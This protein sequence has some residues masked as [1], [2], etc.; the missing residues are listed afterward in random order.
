MHP[1]T[2][3]RLDDFEKLFGPRGACGGCWCMWWRLS[4]A[5]YEQ[6][7][8][9]GNRAAMR[10]L[11]RSGA[12]P[13]VIALSDDQAVGWCG[14]GP[15]S[16]YIRLN[17]SRILRPVRGEP[18]P[19]PAAEGRVWSVVCFYVARDHR[20]QGVSARLLEGAAGLAR[21]RGATTLEGYPLD[22]A[23]SP[24]GRIPDLF[25]FPGIASTFVAAGFREVARRS[26]GR[27]I[28]QRTLR[29]SRTRR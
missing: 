19:A 5:D 7:K 8:G 25:A 16:S 23:K 10:R 29:A 26:P 3:D 2:P 15:R 28:M 9:A 12:E 11:I 18:G 17:R 21:R 4:R 6:R 14:V 20:N 27:P 24:A 13:G 22:P 1:L